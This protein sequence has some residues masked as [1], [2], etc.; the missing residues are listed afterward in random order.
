MYETTNYYQQQYNMGYDNRFNLSQ[1]NLTGM[2]PMNQPMNGNVP[3]NGMGMNGS[4][5]NGHNFVPM[6]GQV[7]MNGGMNQMMGIPSTMMKPNGNEIAGTN[8]GFQMNPVSKNS[9]KK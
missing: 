1:L 5:M 9:K 6:N 3:V 8:L 2:N 7:N 4:N